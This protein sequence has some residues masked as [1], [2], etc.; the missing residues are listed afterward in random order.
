MLSD[1]QLNRLLTETSKIIIDTTR[2]NDVAYYLQQV[3]PTWGLILYTDRGGATIAANRIKQNFN[4]SLSL[5]TELSTL[6]ISLNVGISEW[7]R[8]NM[9]SPHDLIDQAIKDSEYDVDD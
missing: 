7:N 2:D 1:Q 3:V 5:S 8:E 4:N 6:N 9:N